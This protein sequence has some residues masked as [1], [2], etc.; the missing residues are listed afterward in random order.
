MVESTPPYADLVTTLKANGYGETTAAKRDDPLARLFNLTQ[1]VSMNDVPAGVRQ[2]L[3]PFI[4][5]GL[6]RVVNDVLSSEVRVVPYRGHY[7]LVDSPARYRHNSEKYSFIGGDGIFLCDFVESRLRESG[8][9][10]GRCLDLCAGSGIVGMTLAPHFEQTTCAEIHPPAISWARVNQQVNGCRSVEVVLSNLYDG[11][12]GRYSVIVANPSYSI[13]PE[14][15]TQN[16]KM[17]SYELGGG[18]Y[19][20]ELTIDIIEGLDRFLTDEGRAF[21]FTQDPIVRGRDTLADSI[22]EKFADSQYRFVIHYV[23]TA[24]RKLK[25]FPEFYRELG[26]SR[27][28]FVVITIERA[29]AF[30]LE[31]R[32]RSKTEELREWA[33]ATLGD[34]TL[35]RLARKLVR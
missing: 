17:L 32:F 28:Y 31:R 7:F 14:S 16:E 4:E 34:H 15:H 27:L 30:R 23:R 12:A 6:L 24:R 35:Y 29:P 9:P 5:R 2:S 1:E 19:G 11:V 20:L 18:K 10:R 33:R 3:Q 13:F 25:R 22:E 21:I 8:N 26:I